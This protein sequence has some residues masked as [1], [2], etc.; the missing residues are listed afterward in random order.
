MNRTKCMLAIFTGIF[1]EQQLKTGGPDDTAQFS[2][3][4]VQCIS[5]QYNHF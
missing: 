2:R 1:K 5:N 3:N 4:E